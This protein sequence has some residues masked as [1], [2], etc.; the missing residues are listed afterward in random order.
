MRSVELP[1]QVAN[2]RRDICRLIVQSDGLLS[3]EFLDPVAR[4]PPSSLTTSFDAVI[5]GYYYGSRG[6]IAARQ[7]HHHQH[8]HDYRLYNVALSTIMPR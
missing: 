7:C 2:D 3:V 6:D 1:R 8:L 5:S 4:I